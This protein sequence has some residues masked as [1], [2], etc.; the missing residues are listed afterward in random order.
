MHYTGRDNNIQFLLMFL[1][2]SDGEIHNFMIYCDY[3]TKNLIKS[4]HRCLIYP[5][6]ANPTK[7]SNTLI[8][9]VSNS[10]MNCLS[11]F[12]HFVGLMLKG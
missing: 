2:F 12:D 11:V 6:S 5:L 4:Y 8:Q 3:L 10:P 1:P 7:W 9:F